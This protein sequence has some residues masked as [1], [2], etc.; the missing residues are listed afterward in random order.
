MQLDGYRSRHVPTS[1][2][3]VHLLEAQGRGRLAPVVLLHGLSSAGMHFLPLL[4]RLRG[5]VRRVVAPD[6]LAHG[7]SDT[8][9]VIRTEPM[10]TALVEALDT[11]LDE[12]AIV[13]GNSMGGLAAVHYAL[14]RP[15]RVRALVLA[16]PGG[17]AMDDAEIRQFIRRF[18]ISTHDEALQFVDRLFARRSHLRQLFAWSVRRQFSDPRV[19]AIL[20]V[21]APEDLLEPEQLAALSMPVLLVW[22]QHERILPREH[23]E[24]FRLHLPQHALIEQP[25]GIG[26]VPHV[27]DAG[28]IARRIVAFAAEVER[29][30]PAARP[31]E[32]VVA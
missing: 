32:L 15:E 18:S 9:P 24:F 2:G 7:F 3:R 12:P 8:P 16:S 20:N 30:A 26:H 4:R 11:V 29:G 21:M 22:G 1:A 23:F 28:A 27:D 19:R 5:S 14:T 10:K 13:F 6:L 17:A 25:E 31:R